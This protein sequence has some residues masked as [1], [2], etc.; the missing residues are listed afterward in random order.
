MTGAFPS[1]KPGTIEGFFDIEAF[2]GKKAIQQGPYVILELALIAEGVPTA[3]VYGLLS[4]DRGLKL[5]FR[6]LDEI[7]SAIVWWHDPS[8]SAS[9]PEEGEAAMALG[10]NGR[11]FRAAESGLPIRIIWDWRL[12]DLAEIIPFGPAR[13]TLMNRSGHVGG[14]RVSISMLDY[15]QSAPR[16]GMRALERDSEWYAHTWELRMRRFQDWLAARSP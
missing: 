9:L 3:Q 14:G 10:C 13:L 6:K 12:T 1:V 16:H 4:T 15:L 11:F 7:R 8:E 5:V 2:P